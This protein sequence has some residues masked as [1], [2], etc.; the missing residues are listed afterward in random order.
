MRRGLDNQRQAAALAVGFFTVCTP[1]AADEQLHKLHN[2]RAAERGEGL[3]VVFDLS[4]SPDYLIDEAIGH[5][6]LAVRLTNFTL[7]KEPETALNKQ[8][9]NH[10]NAAIAAAPQ[11]LDVMLSLKADVEIENTFVLKPMNGN[12]NY[13]LVIDF[14]PAAAASS[15]DLALLTPGP[16][17][18]TRSEET[19]TK[20]AVP[21]PCIA[22]P[23]L[24]PQAPEITFTG[25]D[26][27][28]VEYQDRNLSLTQRHKTGEAALGARKH[29]F[30][31]SLASDQSWR[32][33]VDASVKLHDGD[34]HAVTAAFGMFS[35]RR[36]FA[37]ERGGFGLTP[38]RR[39]RKN[40]VADFGFSYAGFGDRLNITA[41]AAIS[42]TS[43]RNTIYDE[44]WARAY[45]HALD[46]RGYLRGGDAFWQ[47]IDAKVIDSDDISA[48]AFF[49]YVKTDQDFRSNQ[50][51]ALHDL[52][53]EGE[54]VSAGGSLELG[55]TN[56][57]FS[58]QRHDDQYLEF[59]ENHASVERGA[60]KL[61]LTH[62]QS[63][64]SDEDFVFSNDAT[65]SARLNLNLTKMFG[66]GDLPKWAPDSVSVA[67]S[68]RH[69]LEDSLFASA[70]ARRRAWGMGASKSGDHFFTDIYVFWNERNDF[71]D[72][73]GGEA[74]SQFG[75][76]LNQ[77]FFSGNWDFSIY[78]SMSDIRR[79]RRQ[80]FDRRDK[81]FS[82]GA[83]YAHKFKGVPPLKLSVDAFEDNQDHRLDEYDFD[84]RDLSVT[85]STEL[86]EYMW[87]WAAPDNAFYKRAPL[88]LQLS[89]YYGWSLFQDS[90]FGNETDNEA[91]LLLRLVTD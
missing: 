55:K 22:A 90:L 59:H 31:A 58:K 44:P 26:A 84:L 9:R 88:S 46:R 53:F 4:Q 7:P 52:L 39:W 82:A 15:P 66:A 63:R 75:I 30:A 19:K 67:V 6:R 57:A 5:N 11:S 23:I 3:R 76:D 35:M 24:C 74:A 8:A 13:R 79:S 27:A 41:G 25:K 21:G 16:V 34:E 73:L 69:A 47:S 20:K 71:S 54:T 85:F 32:S 72:G 48:S 50:T 10:L 40:S 70:D 12:P 80:V 77:S 18:I 91:R 36:P 42:E 89:A 64:F 83:S 60:A 78:A 81:S 14:K 51:D 1:A 2:I 61:R 38:L 65:M 87:A 28:T 86:Q 68:D 49:S 62:Y 33:E 43:L 29:I 45:E 17:E 56:L 37:G